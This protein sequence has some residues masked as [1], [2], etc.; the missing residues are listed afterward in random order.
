LISL[1]PATLP[2]YPPH[3]SLLTNHQNRADVCGR[4]YRDTS[5]EWARRRS[6]RCAGGSEGR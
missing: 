3:D 6:R 4:T 5:W 1:H 2:S